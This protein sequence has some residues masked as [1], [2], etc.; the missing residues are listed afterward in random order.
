VEGG[1]Q[2]GGE[3]GRKEE[4]GVEE[5]YEGTR[6]KSKGRAGRRNRK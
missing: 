4:G 1:G 2:G 5:K 3:K 6:N